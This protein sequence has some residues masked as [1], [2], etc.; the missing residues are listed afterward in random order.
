MKK[1]LL[2]I[3][4]FFL[5]LHQV[6]A[7]DYKYSSIINIPSPD[8]STFNTYGK[9]PVSLYTGV[10]EVSI[11]IYT[12]NYGDI[13]LPI[14]LKYNINN[15]KPNQFPG[16]TGLGWNLFAGGSITRIQNGTPDETSIHQYANSNKME[17]GYMWSH[18]MLSDYSHGYNRDHSKPSGY[19]DA[20]WWYQ[21]GNIDE[22]SLYMVSDLNMG[23]TDCGPDEFQFNFL[24]YT[25]SIYIDHNGKWVVDSDT[26][27]KVKDV[28]YIQYKDTRA[29]IREG[30]SKQEPYEGTIPIEKDY[31]L[32]KFVLVSPDGTEFTFGGLNAVDYS[33]DYFV[34]Q[35]RGTR[36]VATTWHLSKIKKQ[37][38]DI[39]LDYKVTDP[40][41]NGV[42]SM[43]VQSD[44]DHRTFGRGYN[45]QQVM[46]VALSSIKWA[47]YA[48]YFNYS[49][50]I[51]LGYAKTYC[52]DWSNDQFIHPLIL[53]LA[54]NNNDN[55]GRFC[56]YAFVQKYS[57][58][59]WNQLDRIELPDS[60][61]YV[62]RYTR[63]ENQRLKLLKLTKEMQ[64][65][66]ETEDKYTFTYY[67]NMELPPYLN[68]HYDHFGFYNGRNFSFMF[69]RS[70][71][72]GS[73][74]NS[75][76]IYTA[77]R[78]GDKSAIYT[79]AEMLKEIHY[80]TGGFSNFEYEPHVV[81]KMIDIGRNTLVQP[82]TTTPG[83]V[84]IKRITNYSDREVFINSKVYYYTKDFS[85]KNKEG[86]SSGIMSFT[87][88][89]Y[90]SFSLWKVFD[91]KLGCENMNILTN[92]CQGNT[93]YNQSPGVE[94]ST[95]TECQEDIEGNTI[96]YTKYL[97]TGYYRHSTT[98]HSFDTPAMRT[99]NDECGG[100]I[101]PK[102]PFSSNAKMRGNIESIEIYDRSENLKKKT[103]YYYSKFN[104]KKLRNMSLWI[105]PRDILQTDADRHIFG[106]SYQKFFYSYLPVVKIERDYEGADFVEK[107]INYSYNKENKVS[108]EKIIFHEK[109][110]A[111][112]NIIQDYIQKDYVY[113]G[114]LFRKYA[115]TTNANQLQSLPQTYSDMMTSYMYTSP[116]EIR[117]TKNGKVTASTVYDYS[118]KYDN[119]IYSSEKYTLEVSN[120][121]TNYQ[122]AVLGPTGII[123]DERCR[124]QV[125]TSTYNQYGKINSVISDKNKFAYFW[126]HSGMYPIIIVEGASMEDIFSSKIVSEIFLHA[127]TDSD[128]ENY[129]FLCNDIKQKLPKVN[130]TSYKYKPFVGA[131]EMTNP[132]GVTTYYEYDG[133][134]RLKEIYIKINNKK[135]VLKTYRYNY[136]NN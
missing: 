96:G 119:I 120:P 29:Q 25:G 66:K 112:H 58:L 49:Q 47:R 70:F 104:E 81:S 131:R 20:N 24:G 134:G 54:Y 30:I 129:S 114:D 86:T 18:Q 133:M 56:K 72:N 101:T 12:I 99:I 7:Q 108:T 37:N 45:F 50:S 125:K 105:T 75:A 128:V 126:A 36:P 88:K 103:L 40:M 10:P 57:D 35:L 21:V 6:S 53:D 17:G 136:R 71:Y 90:W 2:N 91:I 5:F 135:Q 76:E 118:T 33:V 43:W 116:I 107:T 92:E 97:F 46:P 117:T 42:F 113:T 1:F 28:S 14:E 55:L 34:Q 100:T 27:F 52:A 44:F 60:T 65:N 87:P 102:T 79:T 67:D 23:V 11:P 64:K 80:P 19:Y 84:R 68:G 61:A 31:T 41:I 77:S 115:D 124:L 26:P 48:V 63:N 51:Q 32:L 89:Y 85:L 82:I 59:K 121:I 94:Y 132:Q 16:V 93:C 130:I 9:I 39:T 109:Q 22:I 95:V 3:C 123:R 83:G 62:F 110:D 122:T 111:N 38:T 8:V 106:G 69:E 15:V 98:M 4:F 74:S 13:S 73:L 127:M 78:E